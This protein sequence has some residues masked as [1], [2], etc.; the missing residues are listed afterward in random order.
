MFVDSGQQSD[1]IIARDHSWYHEALDAVAQLCHGWF[2]CCAA[3][4]STDD[5]SRISAC[6]FHVAVVAHFA[7]VPAELIHLAHHT[8]KGDHSMHNE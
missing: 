1:C 4:R 8:V 3:V 7:S 5:L 6:D 2:Q